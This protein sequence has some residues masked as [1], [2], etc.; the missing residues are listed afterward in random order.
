MW[1]PGIFAQPS[2]CNNINFNILN[3]NFGKSYK[4]N[5][6]KKCKTRKNKAVIAMV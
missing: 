4:E 1:T 5:G 2:I 6:S 3:F